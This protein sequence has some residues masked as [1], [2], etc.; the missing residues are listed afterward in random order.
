MSLVKTL[1]SVSSHSIPV[2]RYF[3]KRIYQNRATYLFDFIV[4]TEGSTIIYN[5]RIKLKTFLLIKKLFDAIFHLKRFRQ[6]LRQEAV[7]SLNA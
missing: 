3:P 4:N 2:I 5:T 1:L 7:D 6:A